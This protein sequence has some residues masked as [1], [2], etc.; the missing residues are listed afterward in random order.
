MKYLHPVNV[1]LFQTKHLLQISSK[2]DVVNRGK[3][4]EPRYHYFFKADEKVS[5]IKLLLKLEAFGIDSILVRWVIGFSSN[6][7]QRAF[8][9]D[10][11]SEWVEA[12]AGVSFGPLLFMIFINDFPENIKINSSCTLMTLSWLVWLKMREFRAAQGG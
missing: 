8:I 11:F 1:V 3:S 5:H 9:G 7:R 2:T 10:N 6:R 4:V 12:T